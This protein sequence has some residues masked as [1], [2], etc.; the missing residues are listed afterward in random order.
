MDNLATKFWRVGKRWQRGD[1][2]HPRPPV[3]CEQHQQLLLGPWC[4][5]K[6]QAANQQLWGKASAST[7]EVADTRRPRTFTAFWLLFSKSASGKTHLRNVWKFWMPQI[8]ISGIPG[9][10]RLASIPLKSSLCSVKVEDIEVSTQIW[11]SGFSSFPKRVAT[12]LFNWATEVSVPPNCKPRA[13]EQKSG[14]HISALL[15][16]TGRHRVLIHTES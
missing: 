14:W 16:I 2:L 12:H 3:T 8:L 9:N 11:A 15:L 13:H 1:L 10:W 7:S 4:G 6:P 5:Y